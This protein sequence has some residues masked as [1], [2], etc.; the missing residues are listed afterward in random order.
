MHFTPL[1]QHIWSALV[2]ERY[3][4]LRGESVPAPR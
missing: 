2:A 1:G 4:K 3:V